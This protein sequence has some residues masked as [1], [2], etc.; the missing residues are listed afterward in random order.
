MAPRVACSPRRANGFDGL[1]PEH[2][3]VRR[4]HPGQF[5]PGLDDELPPAGQ[6][7]KRVALGVPAAAMSFG[8]TNA[9]NNR[10]LCSHQ[11]QL[12]GDEFLAQEQSLFL[13]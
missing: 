7:R 6:F 4:V 8:T 3:P 5:L 9:Q 10:Y 1:L 2:L 11:C 13:D 12:D